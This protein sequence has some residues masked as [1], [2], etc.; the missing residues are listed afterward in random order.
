MLKSDKQLVLGFKVQIAVKAGG[1]S[2]VLQGHSSA[3]NGDFILPLRSQLYG[4]THGQDKQAN[5]CSRSGLLDL[6]CVS[7]GKVSTYVMKGL[8]I[9]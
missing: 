7:S 8:V 3:G 5:G 4:M 6:N 2:V 9:K 1:G